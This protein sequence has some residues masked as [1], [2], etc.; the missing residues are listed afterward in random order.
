MNEFANSLQKTM[1]VWEG[2]APQNASSHSNE[3]PRNV[4][5]MPFDCFY[6]PPERLAADGYRIINTAWSPLYI[7][8]RI[9]PSIESIAANW[10]PTKF[11]EYPGRKVDHEVNSEHAS[12]ILGGQLCAWEMDEGMSFQT[13]I[14]RIPAVSERLWAKLPKQKIAIED[15][16]HHI[17]QV[18][19][20]ACKILKLPVDTCKIIGEN[21]KMDLERQ[22]NHSS[23]LHSRK[24]FHHK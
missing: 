23:T 12:K 13:L 7:T 18:S 17:R 10:N 4:I 21:G 6:Y 3:I 14:P 19:E 8:A 5:V 20:L 24:H 9:Q 16:I 1:V 2:F 22:V 11:G 15:F